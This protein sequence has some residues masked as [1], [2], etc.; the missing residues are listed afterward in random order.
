MKTE[1]ILHFLRLDIESRSLDLAP[2]AERLYVSNDLTRRFPAHEQ[3]LLLRLERKDSDDALAIAPLRNGAFVETHLGLGPCYYEA[4]RFYSEN[5]GHL[6]HEMEYAFDHRTVRANLAGR[7]AHSPQAVMTYVVRPILKGFLMP[8]YNLATVHAA[9]VSKGERTFLLAGAPAAGKSTIA[10]HLMLAGYDLLSDDRTFV[11]L[12]DGSAYA[13]SSLDSLHVTDHTLRM[14]PALGPHVVG[15]KD[16]G[17]K[18]TVCPGELP[19]GTAWRRPSRVTH[20]IQ[21]RRGPVARPMLSKLHSRPVLEDLLRETMI[22][23]RAPALRSSPYPVRE[24]SE[25][26]LAVVAALVRD[27]NLYALEFADHDLPRIPAL[28]DSLDAEN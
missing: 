4:G 24:Y 20:F 6:W 17:G 7:Y 26:I 27:A 13:L 21:L 22:V 1:L 5:Q 28:L 14:F 15:E 9:G 25:F 12:D 16:E 23:F 11:T 18:W 2:W 3:R 10:I 19:R 8:F